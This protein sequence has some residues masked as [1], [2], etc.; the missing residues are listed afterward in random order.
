ML[1]LEL[2]EDSIIRPSLGETASMSTAVSTAT[3]T[4]WAIDPAHSTVEFSVRHMMVATVKGRFSGVQGTIIDVADDPN[5]SSVQVNIDPATVSTG[6]PQRDA[7]LRGPDFF[8]AEKYPAI[9]FQSRR[10]EGSREEFTVYGDL[11]IRDTTR[12]IQLQ[13]TFNGTGTNPWGKTVA[14][15]S[16]EAK[17]NRKDWGLNWNVALE[18]GGVLVS[19]QIKLS[20]EIEAVQQEA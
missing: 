8:D 16:A 13:A 15:F 18:T 2:L 6:D 9:T 5:Q 17:L 12:P 4:I 10:V 7:H 14:G 3:R 1:L 19:D 11:T 20:L